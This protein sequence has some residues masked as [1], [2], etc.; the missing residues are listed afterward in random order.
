MCGRFTNTATSEELM[1]QFGVTVTQN[2]CPRWN[3]VP[4]QSATVI[5]RNSLHAEATNALWGL[6]PT[7]GIKPV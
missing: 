1:S 5:V 4:S 3:V 6:P 2:F 7:T